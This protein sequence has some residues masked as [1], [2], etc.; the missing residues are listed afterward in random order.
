MQDE[1]AFSD[2]DLA[3]LQEFVELVITGSSVP[4]AVLLLTSPV[5]SV[6]SLFFFWSSL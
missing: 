4:S 2:V 6:T 5:R 3:E 1:L